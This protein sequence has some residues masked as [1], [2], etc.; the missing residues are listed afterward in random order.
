MPAVSTR[1]CTIKSAEHVYGKSPYFLMR[2]LAVI[3][4]RYV[5]LAQAI[6][7]YDVR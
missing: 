7:S 2:Q 1:C 5:G 3:R 4:R 6:E